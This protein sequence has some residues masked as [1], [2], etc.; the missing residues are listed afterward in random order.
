M[1]VAVCATGAAL[2]VPFAIVLHTS[3][4]A[5]LGLASLFTVV[6]ALDAAVP[7][8]RRA[9]EATSEFEYGS[10]R[11]GRR[12][13]AV[14]VAAALPVLLVGAPYAVHLLWLLKLYRVARLFRLWRMFELRRVA[15]LRLAELSYWFVLLTHWLS[16]GWLKLQGAALGTGT[17]HRYL[18][19]LYFVMGLATAG[20]GNTVPQ[21][22]GQRLYMIGLMVIG[23]GV[24]GFVIGT[25]AVI[26]ANLDPRRAKHFARLEELSAFMS[27][28]KIPDDLRDRIADHYRYLWLHR[29]DQDEAEVLEGLPTSLRTEVS[30]HMKRD[31]LQAVPLFAGAS[32]DFLRDV[33]LDLEPM[34]FLPGDEVI[35]A[36]TPGREMYFVNRGSVEVIGQDGTPFAQMNAGDFFGEM[37]L[38]YQTPRVATVR[39]VS[40]CH[41][42]RLE[43]AR[44]AEVLESYPEIAQQIRSRADERLPAN[45]RAS[46]APPLP[47]TPPTRESQ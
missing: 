17:A 26:L 43:T 1:W 30:L 25:V 13:L 45:R 40:H 6:F 18:E 31:L 12:R 15:W 2:F 24:Y 11:L 47:T 38:L 27:Y 41:L 46:V 28:R 10:G 37:A 21:T 8:L 39:T 23:V 35:R 36:G 29:L 42:Y 5:R 33:A 4:A 9:D 3:A 16:V 14:D 20:Y 34:V 44:F 19:A 7:Y 22:D 32:D